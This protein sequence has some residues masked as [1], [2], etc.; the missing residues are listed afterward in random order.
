[1]ASRLPKYRRVRDYPAFPIGRA[2]HQLLA[3]I[4]RF[5][6]LSAPQLTRLLYSPTSLTYVQ[7]HLKDLYQGGYLQ[8]V[9]LPTVSPFGSSLAIYALDRQGMAHL[10]Q[11]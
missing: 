1:M 10:K 9:Y 3:S 6:Y 4:A 2:K 5:D 8:R 11:A 7:D